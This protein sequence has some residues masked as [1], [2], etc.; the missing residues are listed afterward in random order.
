MKHYELRV[1]VDMADDL[2]GA[3][4][5]IGSEDALPVEALMVATEHILTMAAMQ[6]GAGFEKALALLCEGA[7]SNKIKAFAGNRTQ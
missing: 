4:V 7:R 2:S 5:Q 1:I 6:S 3:Q